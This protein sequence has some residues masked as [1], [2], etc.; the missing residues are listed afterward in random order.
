MANR[1]LS[2]ER[3]IMRTLFDLRITYQ[4]CCS[5]TAKLGLLEKTIF[6]YIAIISDTAFLFDVYFIMRFD[7][8]ISDFIK[9]FMH[10]FSL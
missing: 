1:S 2:C 3:N 7:Y 8:I 9:C 5:D 10:L 4:V 6:V